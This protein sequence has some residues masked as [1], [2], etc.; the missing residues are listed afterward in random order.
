MEKELTKEEQIKTLEERINSQKEF[1]EHLKRINP[2]SSALSFDY[3]QLHCMEDELE[4][5]KKG[6]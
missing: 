4:E 3:Y 5:L 2:Y 1:I 6:E